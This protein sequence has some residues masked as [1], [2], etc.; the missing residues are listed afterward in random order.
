MKNNPEE[1]KDLLDR[2]LREWQVNDAP[3]APVSGT[4]LGAHRR[5]RGGAKKPP[6]GQ[7]SEDWFQLAFSRPAVALAYA[8][9]LLFSGSGTGYWQAREKSALIE[10]S[11]GS[12]YVQ[13]VDPYQKTGM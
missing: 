9:V 3:A 13:S 4:G 7:S 10:H 2:S 6:F 8:L 11:L 5:C 1:N 12:R